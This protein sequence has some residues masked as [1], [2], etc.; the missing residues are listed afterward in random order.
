MVLVVALVAS[1]SVADGLQPDRASSSSVATLLFSAAENVGVVMF[2]EGIWM[3]VTA[4]CKV[5][6]CCLAMWLPQRLG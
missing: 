5:S 6:M 1:V 4:E 2:I 3:E